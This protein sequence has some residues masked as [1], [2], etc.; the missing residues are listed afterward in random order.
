MIEILTF[1]LYGERLEPVPI[2]RV[3]QEKGIRWHQ[4]IV[5]AIARLVKKIR[6]EENTRKKTAHWYAEVV[7]VYKPGIE[8]KELAEEFW[9]TTKFP[10][11][12]FKNN[13]FKKV[14]R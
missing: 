14:R 5:P 7:P 9:K 6:K 3:K 13:E 12:I 10:R 11:Y 8:Y 2:L 1:Y 4:D